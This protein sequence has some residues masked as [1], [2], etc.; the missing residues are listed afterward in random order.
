MGRKNEKTVQNLCTV[1]RFEMFGIKSIV[2]ALTSSYGIDKVN[3]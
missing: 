2:D 1:C 3:K